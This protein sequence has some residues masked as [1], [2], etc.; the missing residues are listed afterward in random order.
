MSHQSNISAGAPH[1]QQSH[2][3]STRGQA[4]PGEGRHP[5]AGVTDAKDAPDSSA[6]GLNAHIGSDVPAPG[7][8]DLGAGGP[9]SMSNSSSKR[10]LIMTHTA[11][12][13]RPSY[14]TED[15]Y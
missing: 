10:E 4:A 3:D 8:K 6:G 11:P 15:G 1:H 7:N 5:T 12:L 9:T 14:E 2:P 13:P